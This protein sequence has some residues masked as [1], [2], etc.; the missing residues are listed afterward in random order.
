MRKDIHPQYYQ[1][2]KVKCACGNS[3]TVGSTIQE[4]SLGICSACH[5]FFTGKDKIVDTRGRVDKF[6]KKLEKSSEKSRTRKLK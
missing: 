4:I 5:P 3:F 1:D 2:A 6:K